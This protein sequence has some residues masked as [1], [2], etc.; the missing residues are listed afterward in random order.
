[1]TVRKRFVAAKNVMDADAYETLLA[2]YG[3]ASVS[4]EQAQSWLDE[5][6]SL[7]N[8]TA[9]LAAESSRFWASDMT[10][11]ARTISIDGSQRLIDVGL[12]REALYWVIATRTRS[13]T[14]M[15]DAGEDT[16]PYERAFNDMT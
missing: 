7:F 2:L 1:L 8:H 11:D 15:N 13:L 9:P 10:A 6:A 12:H 4:K 14:I 5:T 3:F 16:S